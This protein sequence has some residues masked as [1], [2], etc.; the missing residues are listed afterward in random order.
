MDCQLSVEGHTPGL[1]Y[2]EAP[3]TGQ[4]ACTEAMDQFHRTFH[5]DGEDLISM[6]KALDMDCELGEPMEGLRQ[7]EIRQVHQ[8]DKPITKV[9]PIEGLMAVSIDATKAREK[10]GQKTTGSGRKRYT[11][12]FKDTK[13]ATVSRV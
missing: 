5:S 6:C 11:M 1:P 8:E 13:V 2:F 7:Q 3:F 12:G 10:L 9:A 4:N